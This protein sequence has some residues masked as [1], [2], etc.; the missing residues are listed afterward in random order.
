MGMKA[1]RWRVVF[2]THEGMKVIQ[3]QRGDSGGVADAVTLF[4][5]AVRAAMER[6]PAC[7][8]TVMIGVHVEGPE[9]DH[10]VGG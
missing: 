5:T 2:D 1:K 10:E 6:E 9:C 8:R 7:C 3:I 4:R